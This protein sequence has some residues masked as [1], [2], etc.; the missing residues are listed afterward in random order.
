MSI[1]TGTFRWTQ[2]LSVN[3]AIFDEQHKK[4]ID[5]MNELDQALR[6]GEGKAALDPVLDKLVE[7]ALVHFAAEESLMEQHGF[8]GLSTHRAQHEEFRR[9][10]AEYLEAHKAGKPGVP[11]SLL[12]F[13][14][15]WLK[16]HLSKTDRLY[17]GF[18]NARGV[19]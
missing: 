12:F 5:T 1:A 7:Y 19:Y 8:P 16:N 18:L 2:V 14:Q 9:R 10:L 6:K 13:M 17:S 11:V 3:I 15:E 4:L